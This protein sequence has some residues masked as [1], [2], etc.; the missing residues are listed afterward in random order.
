MKPLALIL[1]ILPALAL[2]NAVRVYEAGGA[3]QANRPYVVS[4][5]FARGDFP[6]GYYPK[7]Y[8]DGV[9]AA[10]WQANVLTTWP[11]G[12]VMT[13]LVATRISLSS[14]GAAV[15]DFRKTTDGCHLGNAATCLAAALTQAQMLAFDTGTGAGSWDGQIEMTVSP[16]LNAANA[17]TMLGTGK[18]SCWACGP[19]LTWVVVEDRTSAWSHNFGWRWDAG[20]ATW[21]SADSENYRSISPTFGLQFW[22]DPD[23]AG[24]LSAWPGVEIE[25]AL[26]S[27]LTTRLQRLPVTLLELKTGV[28]LTNTAYSLSSLNFIARRVWHA[29]GWSGMAP[30]D[31]QTDYNFDYLIS[32]KL[33]LPYEK[34]SAVN[35]D[36]DTTNSISGYDA[37]LAGED[38][39]FCTDVNYCAQWYKATGSTGAR[40]DLG[41]LPS[42]YVDG[43]WV[44]SDTGRTAAQRLTAWQKL[45]IGPADAYTSLPSHYLESDPAKS[46]YIGRVMTLDARPSLYAY[47]SDEHTYGGS[48]NYLTPVCT[49]D[50][51]NGR[52]DAAPSSTYLASWN[53]QGGTNGTSH[54]TDYAYLPALLTGRWFHVRLEKDWASFTLHTHPYLYKVGSYGLMIVGSN[55]RAAPWTLRNIMMAYI[56]TPDSDPDKA[57]FKQKLEYNELC[58]EGYYQITSGNQA[59][60]KPVDPTCAGKT[61]ANSTEPWCM[62]MS[63]ALAGG[64]QVRDNPLGFPSFGSMTSTWPNTYAMESDFFFG[65]NSM[66]FAWLG[67]VG[68]FNSIGGQPFFRFVKDKVAEYAI[69]QTLG[70]WNFGIHVSYQSANQRDYAGTRKFFQ[71]WS[72]WEQGHAWPTTLDTSIGAVDT[73][74]IIP[75]TYN[76]R[77]EAW[78][79]IGSEWIKTCSYISN[80]PTTGKTTYT[81]CTGGRGM[82][83]TTAA[84]HTA[85]DAAT[86]W[87]RT[88]PTRPDS[89]HYQQIR[90]YPIRPYLNSYYFPAY[91]TGLKAIERAMGETQYRTA[92]SPFWA[93]TQLDEVRHV[94]AE[95]GTGTLTLRWVAP[96]GAACQVYVGA[97]EPASSLDSKDPTATARSREQRYTATGLAAGTAYYRIT[98]GHGR[99]GGTVTVN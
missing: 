4:R 88:D 57:Y 24:N 87:T 22:P 21:V 49:A 64:L 7:P 96:S 75:N 71:T 43:L 2:D 68:A 41:L 67:T 63:F 66:T 51:C 3:A 83:G 12:S 18:W 38:P 78:W 62:G 46:S 10:V 94:R 73:T 40:G 34:S 9:A 99:A 20:T 76:Q 91:G 17:R 14:G 52:R 36:A 61:T 65:Y 72:D 27:G 8:I 13:A 92:Q 56:V 32:T 44:M 80:S 55:Y 70:V 28:G 23:G 50:P 6:S 89:Q 69:G 97:T 30:P 26:H 45:L 33:I 82:W 48:T 90:W 59:S 31:V 81:V 53:A 86:L 85:G 79:K 25:G 93:V 60:R 74:L 42:W 84:S 15:I 5:S 19:V 58:F 29:T 47:S 35:W 77:S 16:V 95:P 11:D 98:C 39:Q 1:T 37:K 54:N